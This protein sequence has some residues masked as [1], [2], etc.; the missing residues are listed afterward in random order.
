MADIHQPRDR[1]FRAVFSDAG[2]AASLIQ[3]A[4]SDSVRDSFDWTTLTL[5]DGTFFDED[6]GGRLRCVRFAADGLG[7]RTM[8]DAETGVYCPSFNCIGHV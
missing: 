8:R 3:A 7:R 2:E 5:V 6:L 1:L 4:L